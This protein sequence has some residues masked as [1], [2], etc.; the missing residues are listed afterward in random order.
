MGGGG[1][2]G[3]KGGSVGGPP[4][5]NRKPWETDLWKEFTTPVSTSTTD[6]ST[7]VDTEAPEVE[8]VVEE[9]IEPVFKAAVY[10]RNSKYP[11][12]RYL[13]SA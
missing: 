11:H 7:T 3:G 8:E 1:K 9:V 5:L 10:K 4:W 6:S 13:E 12:F 2:G